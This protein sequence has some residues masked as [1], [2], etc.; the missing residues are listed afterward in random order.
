MKVT[1]ILR[2]KGANVLTVWPG[3]SV[4][5]AVE[6]M[7]SA[8]VGALVVIDDGGAL[9]G[10]VSERDVL[11]ALASSGDSAMSLPVSDVISRHVITC[12]K[13]DSLGDLMAI[14]TNRRVRHLPVVD[15]GHVVGIVSIGDLVKARLHEL[16]TESQVLRDAYLRVR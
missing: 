8:G 6:R 1:E 11:R 10:V 12:S 5:S 4:R 15:G 14:M 9:V 3:A 2:V 16:E 7:A 13:D